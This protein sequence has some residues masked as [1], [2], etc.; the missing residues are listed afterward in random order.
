MP[1]ES[2]ARCETWD[3]AQVIKGSWKLAVRELLGRS[4]KMSLFDSDKFN[5]GEARL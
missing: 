1:V 4:V 5:A 3:T 2:I